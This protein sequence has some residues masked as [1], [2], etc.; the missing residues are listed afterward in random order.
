MALRYRV[1][2]FG[3]P[4][5]PWRLT[6]RQAQRDASLLGLG[7]FDEWGQFFLDAQATIAWAREEAIVPRRGEERR[8][9]CTKTPALR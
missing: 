7:E 2:A 1:V 4:Q 6:E 3:K 9:S 5:A 8:A